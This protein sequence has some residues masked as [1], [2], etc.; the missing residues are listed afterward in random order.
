MFNAHNMLTNYLTK[1]YQKGDNLNKI[2]TNNNFEE[3]KSLSAWRN[4]LAKS[5]EHIEIVRIETSSKEVV[6]AGEAVVVRA[7]IKLH[8]IHHEDILTE[9]YYG[10]LGFQNEL[11]YPKRIKMEREGIDGDVSV[12]KA[13]ISCSYGG[14][15]G[16]FV[17]ILPGHKHLATEFIAKLIKWEG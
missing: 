6:F 2:L 15:Y 14:R 5:W 10:S 7:Y 12:F 13:M 1:Y 9:V 17:R 4:K 8:D 16:Y 3:A 11:K